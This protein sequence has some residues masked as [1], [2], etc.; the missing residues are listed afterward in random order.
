MAA[1]HRTLRFDSIDDAMAEA[2]R[3][4]AGQ[5]QTTGN[6]SLGQIFE[7]LARTFEDVIRERELPPAGFPMRMLSRM[8]RPMVL[9]KAMTGFKLPAKTQNALWPTDEVSVEDGLAHL[10]EA[11]GKFKSTEPLPKHVFFGN[12]TRSQH[13]MLQ[14]RHFEGHLG[15][16][17]PSTV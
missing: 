1:E 15:F 17:K 16:V 14:C 3:L 8:M 13:E 2:E 10:R 7:H 9:R 6:F 11:Y 5:T 12:M 4:A